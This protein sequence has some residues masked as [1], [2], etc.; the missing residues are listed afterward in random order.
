MTKAVVR[1]WGTEVGVLSLRDGDSYASFEY[2]PD[3]LN[4]GIEISPF[5]LPLSTKVYSFPSLPMST[6]K[7]LPGTFSDSLPDRFGNS[8]INAWLERNGRR[9]DSINAVE[10]LC[11]TGKRGM[12]AFEYEPVLGGESSRADKIQIDELVRLSNEVMASRKSLSITVLDSN[13]SELL[14]LVKVGSSAG[15]ARAKALVAWNRESGEMKSGQIS[16][17]PGFEYFLIKFD[18]IFGNGDHDF[19]DSTNFCKIEY[20]YYLMAVAAGIN[21][22]ES[23][24]FNE[25]GRSHFMTKRF[26]RNEYGSKI[27]MLTLGGLRHFDFNSPG[28]NSYEEVA[29]TITALGLNGPTLEEFYK[30]MCFNIVCRNQDDHVKNISFLMDKDGSWSLSPAYD[31]TYSYRP[32]SFWVGQHQMMINGKRS[33]FTLDDILATASKM[34][35][36]KARAKELLNLVESVAH[37]FKQYAQCAGLSEEV[38]SAIESQFIYL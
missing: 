15:G 1:L 7:G 25:G 21:M 5:T 17:G 6:F 16:A 9:P 14:K 8:V 10:R 11:Y 19:T 26:D 20:S 31:I 4:S 13:K 33:N 3:F 29:D 2:I 38:S 23:F 30:R 18:G 12:G 27:H 36:K 24:L 37:N 28:T 34:N 22:T 32:D 35:I